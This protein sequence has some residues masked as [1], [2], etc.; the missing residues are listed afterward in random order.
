[1]IGLPCLTSRHSATPRTQ[2]PNSQQSTSHEIHQGQR[3]EENLRKDVNHKPVSAVP[4]VS[5]FCTERSVGQHHSAESKTRPRDESSAD[6]LFGAYVD[7]G[8]SSYADQSVHGVLLGQGCGNFQGT[9]MTPLIPNS[10]FPREE[11]DRIREA[12]CAGKSPLIVSRAHGRCAFPRTGKLGNALTKDASKRS[13]V[14]ALPGFC[15]G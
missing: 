5:R 10:G 13:K 8:P 15:Q 7:T 11:R 9:R 12:A 2:R 14:Q 1:V 3:S 6:L 4:C